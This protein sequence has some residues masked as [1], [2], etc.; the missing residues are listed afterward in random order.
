MKRN[1]KN[2]V[3]LALVAVLL[4]CLPATVSGASPQAA[5]TLIIEAAST[6]PADHTIVA[7]PASDTQKNE[8]VSA[9]TAKDLGDWELR[10]ATVLV[11]YD[12]SDNPA[13]PSGGDVE[14]YVYQA[15]LHSYDFIKVLHK[16]SSDGEWEVLTATVYDGYFTFKPSSF[17]LFAFVRKN[18][19]PPATPP[20][21]TPPASPTAPVTPQ[22]TTPPAN[23]TPKSPQ[24]GVYR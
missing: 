13:Q 17:S 24:T 12:D 14:I 22:N 6:L 10:A 1:L 18:G 11:M 23:T 8:I 2:L 20:V 21:I 15:D 19:T 16:R 7:T 4:V 3:T 5:P 9:A